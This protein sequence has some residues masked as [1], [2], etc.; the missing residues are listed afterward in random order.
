MAQRR[1]RLGRRAESADETRRRIVTATFDLHAEKGMAATSMKDIAERAGVS[2][3]T[4]YHHFPTYSHAIRA[5]GEH[6]SATHPLPTEAVFEEARTAG[7]RIERLTLALYEFYARLPALDWVRRERHVD[8]TLEHFADAEEKHRLRLV[9]A[10]L[11]VR[12]RRDMRVRT[13]AALVDMDTYRAFAR[14]FPDT[15][16][17]AQCAAGVANA[18]LAAPRAT[19]PR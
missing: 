16:S 15:V 13:I 6:T 19:R 7:E 1:Y 18:W 10:A 11:G 9:A 17:A 12:D 14:V 3:G 8:P 4:V 2:V 5:C